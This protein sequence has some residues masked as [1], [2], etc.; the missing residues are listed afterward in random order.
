MLGTGG[1]VDEGGCGTRK[2]LVFA[3]PCV[4]VNFM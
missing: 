1:V 4:V 2:V 3:P